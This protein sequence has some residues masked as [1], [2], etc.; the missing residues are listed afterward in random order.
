MADGNR[1]RKRNDRGSSRRTRTYGKVRLRK[2]RGRKIRNVG[3]NVRRK[4]QGVLVRLRGEHGRL[5]KRDGDLRRGGRRER[6]RRASVERANGE[7]KTG[8]KHARRSVARTVPRKR[9][10]RLVDEFRKRG[11]RPVP[12]RRNVRPERNLR[13][14]RIR[15]VKRRLVHPDSDW[16]DSGRRNER[17]NRRDDGLSDDRFGYEDDDYGR[18]R[19][20][21][22]VACDIQGDRRERG[23]N[24]EDRNISGRGLD[25]RLGR[26]PRRR[27][28]LE[29]AR[30]SRKTSC[31]RIVRPNR[32]ERS[33]GTCVFRE[34][35]VLRRRGRVGRLD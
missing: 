20:R 6:F 13:S 16:G 5:R 10:R 4:G 28:D 32:N 33:D 8:R 25:V 3:G 1:F 31:G 17:G 27:K 22:C 7:D 2:R 34:R 15:E 30:N 19:N 23:R 18:F 21:G 26:L 29:A 12:R 14:W 9:T 11:S 35:S 24:A